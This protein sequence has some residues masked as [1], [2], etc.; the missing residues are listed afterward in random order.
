MPSLKHFQQI[1]FM[2][3][4]LIIGEI[5]SIMLKVWKIKSCNRSSRPNV[6]C[7]KGALRNF[8]KFTGK[9]LCQ[10]LLYNKVPGLRVCVF[11]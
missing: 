8:A 10:S 6:F 3:W 2:L 1:H 7:K 9:N 11:L 5:K 4:S